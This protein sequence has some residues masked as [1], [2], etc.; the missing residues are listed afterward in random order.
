[1]RQGGKQ[2]GTKRNQGAFVARGWTRDEGFLTRSFE[3]DSPAGAI[4]FA[5]EVGDLGAHLDH[6]PEIVIRYPRVTVSLGRHYPGDVSEIDFRLASQINKGP[7]KGLRT[8]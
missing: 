2:A 8:N 5:S 3:F 1:M 7:A 4:R 6:H